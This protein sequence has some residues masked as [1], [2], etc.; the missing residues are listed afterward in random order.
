MYTMDQVSETLVFGVAGVIV[1]LFVDRERG[2][3]TKLEHTTRELERVYTEL[4]ENLD[5]L[6]KAERMFAVGQLSASL[7]HEIRNPLASIS[8]ATGILKRGHGNPESI[9]DCVEIIHKESQR[10]N[11]LLTN[12]ARVRPA[13]RAALSGHRRGGGDRFRYCPR[14]ALAGRERHLFSNRR[15]GAAARS[16][17]RLRAA[18][19]SAAQSGDQRDSGDPQG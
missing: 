15:S 19:T 7:A 11:K 8:G 6:R 17:V 3:R 16:R 1:G 13:A 18:Q 12:L 4:R 9:S 2:Q 14:G 10:L 5:R